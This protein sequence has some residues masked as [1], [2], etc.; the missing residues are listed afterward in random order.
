M[1]KY[2]WMGRCK[3]NVR[4]LRDIQ[5]TS[6]S[7]GIVGRGHFTKVTAGPSMDSYS[8]NDQVKK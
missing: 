6:F 3:I 4:I 1:K 5:S 2:V 7:I 8:K